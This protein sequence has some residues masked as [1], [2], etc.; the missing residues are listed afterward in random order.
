[1]LFDDGDVDET[2][3]NL[4]NAQWYIQSLHLQLLLVIIFIFDK[5]RHMNIH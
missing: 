5:E 3:S 1:M 4:G 2:L